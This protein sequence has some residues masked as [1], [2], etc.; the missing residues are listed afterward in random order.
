MPSCDH[1]GGFSFAH[2]Q[3][4]DGGSFVEA[5]LSND[6]VETDCLLKILLLWNPFNFCNCGLL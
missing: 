6:I 4:L 1:L 2:F 5:Y 3:D